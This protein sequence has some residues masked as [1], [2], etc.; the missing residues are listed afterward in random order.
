M[1]LLRVWD[2]VGWSL[3]DK[4]NG[5]VGPQGPEGVGSRPN[6]NAGGA[7]T[8]I[9]PNPAIALEKSG[10]LIEV[11]RKWG[12]NAAYRAIANSA[13]FTVNPAGDPLQI[14]CTPAVDA[15]WDVD[16]SIGII[17]KLDA[18]YH[19]G[20][21]ILTLSPA[22]ADGQNQVQSIETQHVSVQTWVFRNVSMTWK[23]AANTTYTCTAQFSA[24]GGSWEFHQ[25]T[26]FLWMGG[27]LFAQ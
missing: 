9:Y 7:L 1:T 23:L 24:S 4:V 5:P 19:Y 16:C 14:S 3:V 27:R 6:G 11:Q 10:G 8:G 15:W 2:G 26:E 25:G 21:V 13:N 18:A 12:E 20:Y 17:H 22:D